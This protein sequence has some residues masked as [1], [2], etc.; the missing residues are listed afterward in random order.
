MKYIRYIFTIEL[1]LCVEFTFAQQFQSII[2]KDIV[3]AN[4]GPNSIGVVYMDKFDKK[5]NLIVDKKNTYQ[6]NVFGKRIHVLNASTNETEKLSNGQGAFRLDFV[7][8]GEKLHLVM[9][10]Y[11]KKDKGFVQYLYQRIKNKSFKYKMLVP[12]VYFC[13]DIDRL[14]TLAGKKRFIVSRQDKW[15][16]SFHE[17]G[18]YPKIT[19][20]DNG[21]VFSDDYKIN[22]YVINTYDGVLRK[23]DATLPTFYEYFQK[24]MTFKDTKKFF[25]ANTDT[26]Q[27]DSIRGVYVNKNVYYW[28]D[29]YSPRKFYVQR[30]VPEIEFR[31]NNK[32]FDYVYKVTLHGVE[33]NK[34]FEYVPV[35]VFLANSQL[36][37]EFEAYQ[38]K[39]ETEAK[40]EREA[41]L[42]RLVKKY[43]K[44]YAEDIL[45]GVP[46]IGMSEEMCREACGE[47][48]DINTTITKYS[49]DEQWVYRSKYIYL[50]NGIV[51]AIQYY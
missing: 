23:I 3:L 15:K 39:L 14:D 21:L 46:R 38:K 44:K 49:Y 10:L 2:G 9:P 50:E 4:G 47:P 24:N 12:T 25:L 11:L 34:R 20:T 13:E 41:K 5:G 8:K 35:D 31:D 22:Q 42:A 7:Y 17:A 6:T 32:Y 27:I 43:G 36:A 18:V 19:E 28:C 48:E 45:I 37:E 30:I 51:T 16:V 33:G 29:D 40:Q 26:T 1:M